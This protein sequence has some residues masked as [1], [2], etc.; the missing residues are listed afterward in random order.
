MKIRAPDYAMLR[1]AGLARPWLKQ[2]GKWESAWLAPRLAPLRITKPVFIAG[3]ARS[4]T[5]I[6][7]ELLASLGPLATHRYRDFPF[8][9]VPYLWNRYLDLFPRTDQPVERAHKDRISI[10]RESPEGFEEPVWRAFFPTLRRS[11]TIPPLSD[12]PRDTGFERFFGDHLKKII[13]LRNGCRYLSKNNYNLTRVAYLG[14]LFSDAVFLLPVRH[15]VM[16]VVSLVRQHRLFLAYAQD[17]PRVA[18]W[19]AAAGHNE[20]GPQRCPIAFSE[21]SA[22][23]TLEAWQDGHDALGYAIQWADAYRLAA[24][25]RDAP[26][27]LSQRVVVLRYED[28]CQRPR[29]TFHTLLARME[30]PP[31]QSRSISLERIAPPTWPRTSLTRQLCQA[32]WHETAPVARQFGYRLDDVLEQ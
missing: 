20:F 17:D 8:V 11:A 32:I 16:Q 22:Q 21:Q 31:E 29:E 19:L 28:L 1:F 12:P 25:L 4:G 3:L 30:I 7:L 15:P 24:A 5:T 27:H 14:R 9:L 2:L 26:H 6:L 13:L 23:R 10:T 18:W